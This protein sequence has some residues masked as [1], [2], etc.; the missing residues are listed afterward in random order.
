MLFRPVLIEPKM[1][2]FKAVEKVIIVFDFLGLLILLLFLMGR[3]RPLDQEGGRGQ[4]GA[5]RNLIDLRGSGR[6][7]VGQH[8]RIFERI[9]QAKLAVEE[10]T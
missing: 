7:Q 2:C 1:L 8:F 3:L 6:H 9:R 10:S 4:L 5:F